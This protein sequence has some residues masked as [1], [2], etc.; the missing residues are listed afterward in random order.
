MKLSEIIV[1]EVS[2]KV[3]SYKN[4]LHYCI[5]SMVGFSIGNQLYRTI[6]VYS[7]VKKAISVVILYIYFDHYQ[8]KLRPLIK[9]KAL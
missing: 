1:P 7:M 2:G 8:K 9:A 6:F 5:D 4:S 3:D